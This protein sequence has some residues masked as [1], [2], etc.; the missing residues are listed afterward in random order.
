MIELD[1]KIAETIQTPDGVKYEVRPLLTRDMKLLLQFT[2]FNKKQEELKKENKLDELNKLVYDDMMTVANKLVDKSIV[3]QETGEP[4]PE[5]YRSPFTQ[6]IKLCMIV[7]K[8][9]VGDIKG[10]DNPLELQ[11]KYFGNLEEQSTVLEKGVGIKTP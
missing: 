9:T 6:L 1:W 5:I 11:K 10:N 3:N 2:E 8:E 7:I 4:L